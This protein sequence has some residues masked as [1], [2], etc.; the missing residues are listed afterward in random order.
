VNGDTTT[1]VVDSVGITTGLS[2]WR[3]ESPST[4]VSHR[5]GVDM[6]QLTVR[7][8]KSGV[9][10]V[11]GNL[12]LDEPIDVVI[13]ADSVSL[14]EIGRLVQ[15]RQDSLGGSAKLDLRIAGTRVLPT[16]E[17]A[18]ELQGPRWGSVRLETLAARGAYVDRRLTTTLDLFRGGQRAL[19]AEATLPLDLALV[20]VA[21]RQ[22]PDSLRGILRTDRV[23]LGILE[24]LTPSISKATG[25]LNAQ[26][27]L[28]GTWEQ[29]RLSGG[30]RIADGA[31]SLP[32]LGNVRLRDISGGVRFVGDSI[33]L[34]TIRARSAHGNERPGSVTIGGRVALD[35]VAKNHGFDAQIVAQNMHAIGKARVADLDL[36]GR[37][38][39][40]GR[41]K[42]S[43]LSGELTLVRGDIFIPELAQKRIVSLEDEDVYKVVD[44]TVFANKALLP[45][46]L[47]EAVDTLLRYLAQEV[48]IDMG[49]DVWLRS[50]EADIK[51]GGQLF[52]RPGS[53]DRANSKVQP[54]LN[55]TLVT[56]RGRYR[57]NLGIVQRTFEVEAG[58]VKF[59]GDPD[60]NPTLDISAKHVVRAIRQGNDLDVP[61]RLRITGPLYPQ[62]QLE[63]SSADNVQ[64][65]QSDLLSYLV[66]GTPSLAISSTA[67]GNINTFTQVVLPSI[68]SYFA[69]K[70]NFLGL[71][72]LEV[73]TSGVENYKDVTRFS[74]E[75]AG[76]FLQGTR[77]GGGFSIG[78][79]TFISLDFGLCEIG[80]GIAGSP[81]ANLQ[82]IRQ[83]IGLRMERRLDPEGQYSLSA[84]IEP[85]T[86]ALTC[87]TNQN[88]LFK[89][90]AQQFGFDLFR[91]WEF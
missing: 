32:A 31:F 40:R 90:V 80:K 15:S 20:P 64:R 14:R 66:T 12:P 18:A 8:D 9:V 86:D 47:P 34:D 81:D 30:L 82:N 51:L 63:L 2:E 67:S 72:Y 75:S 4:I 55:G 88:S 25:S 71:D 35:P 3:L 49:E 37:L 28:G 77:L 83:S 44:T 1:A 57:L 19:T 58:L 46:K 11:R 6:G 22:L 17:M 87:V 48:R 43:E 16:M 68:G 74:K 61:V 70:L 73:Q 62:P 91:K 59:F 89:P 29:A 26:L 41:L 56:E 39:L 45:A 84:G 79:R 38:R 7:S 54:A 33:V 65:S 21:K 50:A 36:T 24:T 53:S 78:R 5:G 42:G 60:L 13:T 27:Q 69:N 76:N 52:L 10:A 85:A 23:E